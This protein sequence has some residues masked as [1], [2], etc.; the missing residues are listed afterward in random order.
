MVGNDLF[1]RYRRAKSRTNRPAFRIFGK[2]IL[3]FYNDSE[4]IGKKGQ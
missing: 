4:G 1:G 3:E 2:E